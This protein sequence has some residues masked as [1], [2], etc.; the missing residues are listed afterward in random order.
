MVQQLFNTRSTPSLGCN[1]K[2][3][4]LCLMVCMR[5]HQLQIVTVHLFASAYHCCGCSHVGALLK[6]HLHHTCMPIIRCN[7]QW[8]VSALS[9]V[10]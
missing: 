3:L 9:H 1:V 4:L 6:Q 10:W 5:R 2:G 7:M 8:A